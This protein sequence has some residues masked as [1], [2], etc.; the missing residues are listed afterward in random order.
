FNLILRI[1]ENA[2]ERLV[3]MRDVVAP[4]QIVIDEHFPVAVEPVMPSREPMKTTDIES[5]D[6][7]KCGTTVIQ[8]DEQPSFPNPNSDRHQPH[9]L[10]IKI[11][12]FA[13]IR[14]ALQFAFQRIPPAVIGALQ[15]SRLT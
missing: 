13:Q 11:T 8:P 15:M 1:V 6:F 3:Q 7:R 9:R 10:P 2:V 12:Y 4:V 14:R 5:L